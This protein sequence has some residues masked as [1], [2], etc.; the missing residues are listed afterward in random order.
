MVG[1]FLIA[2]LEHERRH[3]H[4][5]RSCRRGRCYCR[6]TSR[7]SQVNE[8]TSVCAEAL[9]EF[10]FWQSFPDLIA[11]ERSLGVLARARVRPHLVLAL[12]F[13]LLAFA[14]PHCIEKHVH[15]T[16]RCSGS[17][18]VSNLAPPQLRKKWWGRFGL[19]DVVLAEVHIR[20]VRYGD[21]DFLVVI[22]TSA[23]PPLV[24]VD[25]LVKLLK[26]RRV[27]GENGSARVP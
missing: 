1:G 13:A 6:S 12:A 19:Q 26:G 27:G 3:K 9:S 4:P 2:R 8:G 10:R 20:R 21:A 11:V 15:G 16:C 18:S 25:Q 17:D 24:L 14:F 7:L 22:E 5:A 23:N